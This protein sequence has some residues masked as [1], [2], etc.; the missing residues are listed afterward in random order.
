MDVLVIYLT[1]KRTG[2][3]FVDLSEGKQNKKKQDVCK[4]RLLL[5]NYFLNAFNVMVEFLEWIDN[6]DKFLS[7]LQIMR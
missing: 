5:R 2:N 3:Y 6:S 7:N 1:S 4:F